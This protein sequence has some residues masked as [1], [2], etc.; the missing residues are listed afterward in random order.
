MY[1]RIRVK[2]GRLIA[3]WIDLVDAD[4][5]LLLGLD[6]LDNYKLV[7]DNVDNVLRSKSFGWTVPMIRAHGYMFVQWDLSE[8]MYT[9]AELERLHLI[10]HLAAQKL[11]NLLRRGTPHRME[12]DT[13]R[14]IR[15][16][17]E[18]CTGCKR[19]GI[20]PY[21]F[22]VSLRDDE[23]IISH[24]VAI[25]LFW[26]S[27]NSILHVV[28]AHAGYQNVTQQKSLSVEHVWDAFLE[29]WLTVY[30]GYPNRI[31]ADQGSL[32]TSKYCGNIKALH[33]K[34][35]SLPVLKFVTQLGY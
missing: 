14:V 4:I 20:R 25:D 31:R 9:R 5:P 21:R 24:E 32:F 34:I 23:V 10:F 35:Y 28:D 17:V 8:V 33:E 13:M 12:K 15:E 19:F 3:F 2:Q 1:V 26:I 16:T 7:A 11:L 27:G 6:L 22:R 29:A 30:V 18:K